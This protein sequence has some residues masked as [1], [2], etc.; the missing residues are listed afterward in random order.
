MFSEHYHVQ[1]E[2]IPVPQAVFF[3]AIEGETKQDE[4]AL[5][6]ALKDMLREDPSLTVRVDKDTGQT[7]LGGMGEL[8]LDIVGNRLKRDFKVRRRGPNCGN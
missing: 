3:S 2:S 8:H 1:L 5:E 4:D 7:L 6:T